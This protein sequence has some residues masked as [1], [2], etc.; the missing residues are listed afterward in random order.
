MEYWIKSIPLKQLMERYG[1]ESVGDYWRP[2]RDSVQIRVAEMENQDYCFLVA[3]HELVEEFLCTKRGIPEPEIQAFDQMF[4]KLEKE[5]EPGDEPDAPYHRE[6]VFATMIERMLAD[7]IGVKWD[8][9]EQAIDNLFDEDK[10][11][12]DTLTTTQR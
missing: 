8:E 2:V 10:P 5:G 6:H 12:Q 11:C 9:Y 3:L 1:A 4:D 7:E